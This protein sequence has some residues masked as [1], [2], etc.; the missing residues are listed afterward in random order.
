MN[1]YISYD[2]NGEE[3][4]GLIP[5]WTSPKNP[6]P[7][8][9]IN[10]QAFYAASQYSNNPVEDYYT[11]Q[12]EMSSNGSSELVD[13][14]NESWKQ[15]QSLR[16]EDILKDLIQDSSVPND[17]KKHAVLQ[18]ALGVNLSQN[19]RDRYVQKVQTENNDVTQADIDHR[20]QWLDS[21]HQI[22]LEQDQDTLDVE[23]AKL[24][25]ARSLDYNAFEMAGG[26]AADMVALRYGVS[27]A[28]PEFMTMHKDKSPIQRGWEFIKS[29]VFPGE[30]N[31]K[32]NQ[33]YNSLNDSDKALFIKDMGD[34]LSYT[35]G[36]DWNKW[37]TFRDVLDTPEGLHPAFRH[38][39]NLAGVLDVM[40]A[41]GFLAAGFA[42]GFL[43]AGKNVLRNWTT[44]DLPTPK[45]RPVNEATRID[46][47]LKRDTVDGDSNPRTGRE[48]IEQPSVFKSNRTGSPLSEADYTNLQRLKVS[49][50]SPAGTLNAN[51]IRK[52]KE[53]FSQAVVEESGELAKALGT[54]KG[55]LIAD[56]V[57]PK[58]D[59]DVIHHADIYNDIKKMDDYFTGVYR[60]TEFDPFFVPVT[61]REIDKEKIFK[62][63]KEVEGAAYS[64]ANS[65][66]R[67]KIDSIEG[68]A[69]YGR[70][71]SYGFSNAEE[72]EQAIQSMK[73]QIPTKDADGLYTEQKNGQWFV[74]RPYRLDYDPYEQF[75]F[76][77]DAVSAK[78][79]GIDA[80]TAANSVIGKWIWHPT[81]RLPEWV[82]KGANR[83]HRVTAKVNAD[84]MGEI[85]KHIK[86][87]A[88]PRF[89]GDAL[90]RVQENQV[91]ENWK[92]FSTRMYAAGHSTKDIESTWKGY[93]VYKRMTD[94]QHAFANRTQRRILESEDFHG[95]YDETGMHIGNATTKLTKQPKQVF[96]LDNGMPIRTPTELQ[97][98]SVVRLE[99]PIQYQGEM[100]AH[101]ILGSK[102][103][104]GSL[105]ENVIP[106]I[107][108]YVPRH[109]I[110]NFYVTRMPRSVKVDGETISD[111]KTLKDSY[112]HTIGAAATR[113]EAKELA[114]RLSKEFPNH[115][116]DVKAERADVGD[117]ILTDYK[118]FKE[119]LEHSKKRGERLP[120]LYGKARLEDPLES[121]WKTI[122]TSVRLD[123]WKDYDTVFRKN[124]LRQYG[125]FTKGEFPQVLTDIKAHG[126]MSAED[127][128]QFKSAQRLF[129][130]YTNQRYKVTHGDELW[131]AGF[132]MLA[133]SIENVVPKYV[134]QALRDTAGKGNLLTRL[135][136]SLASNIFLYLN[137]P[138]QWAVQTQQLLEWSVLDR[139][140]LKIAPTVIPAIQLALVSKATA[141]GKHGDTL[142]AVAHKLSGMSKKEFDAT[143]KALYTEGIPQ[144]VD[145]NMMLHGAFG[146]AK[147]LLD[148]S[149][150]HVIGQG[151]AQAVKYPGQIGKTVG[152]TPAELANTIGTWLFTR[153]RWKKLNPGKEWNTP[154]NV[155]RISADAWEIGKA[156]S[157]RAGAMPYQDGALSLFFQF[158]A[159]QHKAFMEIF[160]SKTFT[161]AERAKLA[162][163]RTLLWGAKGA[164]LGG[165]VSWMIGE[166][167]DPDT[168]AAYHE[169][170]G[171]LVDWIANKQ[172]DMWLRKPGE[173]E[174][175]LSIS[176]SM[177][178]MPE[179]LPYVDF[180]INA[181]K[182]FDDNPS[183][184]RFAF[185]GAIGS[186]MKAAEEIKNIY[187]VNEHGDA[188]SFQKSAIELAKITSGY[189][190]Y[191]KMRMLQEMDDKIDKF[192][193][194]MGLTTTRAQV[195]AQM[196]GII[197]KEEEYLYKINESLRDRKDFIETRAQ[198]I[199]TALNNFKQRWGT[200]EFKEWVR[201][202]QILNTYTPEELRMEVE[203]RVDQLQLKDW[204]SRKDSAYTAI[205]EA[206]KQEN[207]K[208]VNRSLG[209]LKQNDPEEYKRITEQLGIK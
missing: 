135:P 44:V 102:T 108:G 89:L 101:A 105:P 95:V 203:A 43:R 21:L 1:E 83:A 138:R 164:A 128:K 185:T 177:S 5:R 153:E 198:E 144:G 65:V 145:L 91:W 81:Q 56:N 162:A 67:E 61:Q 171:G 20:D 208:Y 41:K 116:V 6:K 200:P 123:V 150:A 15:E 71:D 207:D 33:W 86:H 64:Q 194:P 9:V 22:R 78:F 125:E 51:N 106:K 114:R 8:T 35:P 107:E 55:S 117:S 37:N 10:E 13:R 38:I 184:P 84:F 73:S 172:I 188:A 11:A 52:A 146:E 121:L 209:Y 178:P 17:I 161:A 99:E 141:A 58:L 49:P 204:G 137:P 118:V 190:N 29:V 103:K 19:L 163:V 54:D 186:A 206:I 191:M 139:G 155:S 182:L 57:F 32:M 77:N 120:T 74:H 169:L 181:K 45:P 7:P 131:K 94:Y 60:E 201:V 85:E 129:E 166:H 159:V 42:G 154:E 93:Q 126:N 110:E 82:A 111:I 46:P 28:I 97:G 25:L 98:R 79:L 179:F 193:N 173:K 133:D 27:T 167:T 157:T 66:V 143:F 176:A 119:V 113:K 31:Y 127:L 59:M 26:I 88:Q 165:L 112:T 149:A 170:E 63:L 187:R 104:L 140:Y 69:V 87:S 196:F 50:N 192:G 75:M 4:I 47:V 40:T 76:G 115:V 80:S 48:D 148:P 202:Q 34:A 14:A 136:K 124:W 174:S 23:Q 24:D 195:V 180:I 53:T 130:Q 16:D 90:R 199:H 158:T 92:D 70:N 168:Q 122:Q 100:F 151:I 183:M 72:A 62:T 109:N 134:S 147:Q 39:E 68:V 12:Q 156:M 205:M 160:S 152:Y 30:A 36:F 197:S 175:D 2:N 142:Y 189:S 3:D 132:H 96:D 18:H